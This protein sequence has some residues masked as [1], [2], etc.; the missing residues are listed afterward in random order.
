MTEKD[1]KK[2]TI[3]EYMRC[4]TCGSEVKVVSGKEGTN[5]YEPSDHT[6]IELLKTCQIII[7][8]NVLGDGRYILKEIKEYLKN[9]DKSLAYMAQEK[10]ELIKL[11]KRLKKSR[12]GKQ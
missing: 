1:V 6:A 7:D 8:N 3:A 10:L 5:H 9:Y 4:P 11:R 2:F 12:G